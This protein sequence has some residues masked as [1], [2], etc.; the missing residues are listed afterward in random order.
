LKEQALRDIQSAVIQ[1]SE[2]LETTQ[3]FN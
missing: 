2:D 1:F 3:Q